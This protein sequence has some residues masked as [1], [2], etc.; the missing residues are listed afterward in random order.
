[1]FLTSP[2]PDVFQTIRQL[3]YDALWHILKR[4][5]AEVQINIDATSQNMLLGISHASGHQFERI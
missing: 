1:M 4:S 3:S 5:L 2:G